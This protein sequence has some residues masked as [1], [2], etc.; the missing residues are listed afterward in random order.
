[1][2]SADTKN[3]P[4]SPKTTVLSKD[5]RWS[6]ARRRDFFPPAYTLLT[7]PTAILTSEKSLKGRK[8]RKLMRQ[9]LTNSNENSGQSLTDS[10]VVC[11]KLNIN[12][13]H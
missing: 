6:L 11:V 2:K 8:R 10:R 9:P 7:S 5:S 12:F 1:M 4:T 3:T 13:A